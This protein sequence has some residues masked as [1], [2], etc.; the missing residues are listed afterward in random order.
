MPAD[1][2]KYTLLVHHDDAE[3]QWHVVRVANA[4]NGTLFG[5]ITLAP[6]TTLPPLGKMKDLDAPID[7]IYVCEG[8]VNINGV[9]HSE[10]DAVRLDAEQPLNIRSETA[11]V[12]TFHFRQPKP[13]VATPA[14]TTTT[15]VEDEDEHTEE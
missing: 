5:V 15:G 13:Q 10:E 9:H 4:V 14:P 2:G 11:A 8:T 3:G 12:L 6:F 7:N 1:F